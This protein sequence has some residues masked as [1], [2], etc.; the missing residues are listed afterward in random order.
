VLL[1]ADPTVLDQILSDR[2]A[3]AARNNNYSPQAYSAR[4]EVGHRI[5]GRRLR[6]QDFV[7]H[8]LYSKSSLTPPFP[9]FLFF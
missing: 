5:F 4:I 8:I 3:S 1:C 7:F 6:H 9:F 2:E